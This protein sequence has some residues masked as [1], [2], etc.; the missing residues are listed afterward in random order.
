MKQLVMVLLLCITASLVASCATRLSERLVE[1]DRLLEIAIKTGKPEDWK[2]YNELTA[3]N[4]VFKARVK[5]H[6]ARRAK[7]EEMVRYCLSFHQ[8]VSC[9]GAGGCHCVPWG[10]ISISKNF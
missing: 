3:E 10:L 4:D 6:K 1:E 2:A 7:K 9:N 8:L 5:A